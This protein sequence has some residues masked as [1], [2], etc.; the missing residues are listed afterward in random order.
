M[1]ATTVDQRPKGQG[2][3]VQ[4][5]S[6]HQKDAVND[7]DF[8]NYLSSQ[9]N[10]SNS[11]PPMSDPYM[12]SYYAPSIGFPYSLGE[13]AWS[14]AGDPPMPYLTTYGQMSNGEHHFIPDGVFSQP[15]A[16]GNTP[17]FLSQHGFNF[18]PGNADF[19]TWGTSGSQ[20]Q[21][22]QSSAYSSSY[23]YPP[24]S[25]GRAIADGQAG[26][27]SDTQL[28]KV[29][30]LSSIDQG[31]AGLKLGSDMSAVTKTVGSP[32]G[33]TAGMSS[34][35]ANSMPHVSSSAPKP[36]SWAAIA[37]K[38]AKPQPKLKLKPNMG[39]GSGSTIPPP[40][41]KH[42]MNI[43][44]WEDKGSITKPPLAQQM[45]PPQPL[46]QQQL[47]A[48][49]QPMLQSPLPPHP[50][51]QQLQLQSPQHPQQL[52]SGPPHHHSQPGPPQH[53][54]PPQVQNPPTQNRWVA[55][56]NRGTTFIQNSSMENFGLG[57]G[58]LMSSLPP[59]SEVHPVLEKLKALNDYSPKDFDWNLK[60]GRVFIIKSYS[61][62]DIHRS[63]KYS[64]WCSTEHGNKRLD[65]AY[66]SLSAK[67]PLYLLF[68]VNGSGH[69]CGVAEMKST[70]DY[71]AYA[72]VWS[73]NKW[74][75]KFEVKWIFVK[76]V[77]NNQLRHIRLENNDNKPVTNSRDTQE[78][79]LEKAKQVLKI[80]ATFKHTTSIFDDFTHYEKRQ[81][82]EEA[83][84]RVSAAFCH[85]SQ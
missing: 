6:M 17:P 16:L 63:I 42:N 31:M 38:P 43:G 70:V 78:V 23:G 11:Y 10:Q 49:P 75:G 37:R 85:S 12:P 77:P 45:L 22:T 1:S 25:L 28:S 82:E 57:T 47:L 34:M 53:L 32:L 51:H 33:G 20:G 71:N 62:D 64:I 18:F 8:D 48:Q 39:L 35:A 30:G 19:S 68:S 46:L 2:N 24:S 76:D 29:P 40:P 14:T 56:R 61:E 69:F 73:Q 79:P 21:S 13:A 74:K 9:T 60:N 59:S 66:R 58:V 52:P 54:H 84:R 27:G 7:D 50:Q 81:E 3:K 4:N 5:G 83:M 36:T 15:G 67:G 44:T 65:G 26:F 55:P 41:I 80:I 72:G